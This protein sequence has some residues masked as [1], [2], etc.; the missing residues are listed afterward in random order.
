MKTMRL[1][2]AICI[3]IMA[4][5]CSATKVDESR[6][7][8]SPKQEGEAQEGNEPGNNGQLAGLGS[9]PAPDKSAPVAAGTAQSAPGSRDYQGGN[10]QSYAAAPGSW[11]KAESQPA[12]RYCP[13]PVWPGG[14][15]DTESYDQ[16]EESGFREPRE[17]LPSTFSVDVDTASY[18]NVR[19]FINGGSLPPRD[20]VRI[21]EMVN[22]FDYDYPE[23]ARGKPFS[24]SVEVTRAPW[25]PGHKLVRVAIRARNAVDERRK[26]SNLVFLLDVSGSMSDSNKLPLVKRAMLM[27]LGQLDRRDRVAIVTYA[28]TAGLTL[29]STPADRRGEIRGA[30]ERLEAGGSTAG[31][32]GIQLAY[33]AARENFIRGGI[34]R[35][36]LC[37]DGDFN[38]GISDEVSL[39]RMIGDEAKSGVFLSVFGFGMGNLK[40]SMLEKLAYRGNGFYGYIDNEREARKNMVDQAQGTLVTVAK[41]V[42]IQVEFNPALV[43]SYRLIGYENRLMRA[44]DFANDRKDAGDVG[45]GHRVTAFYEV[46]PAIPGYEEGPAEGF[47]YREKEEDGA[48]FNGEL[49]FVKIRYKEPDGSASRLISFPVR[50]SERG[51]QS[52]STELKFAAAVAEFGLILGESEHRGSANLG[53]VRK[54]AS[55]SIG[56]DNNGYRREF[57]D[58]VRKVEN[59]SAWRTED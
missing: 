35:V 26:P 16:P 37:T 33:S 49:L 15:Y 24:A 57:L 34:N 14:G 55:A 40:D 6:G 58:L 43:Q 39:R 36:I 19:R 51:F 42:K 50:D 1:F 47:R 23:P 31:G 7:R 5:S 46:V 18:A 38:V 2:T 28:G 54:I 10:T 25:A 9:N 53:E 52:A 30:I 29:E 4:V 56:R 12:R 3:A 11:R 32:R 21:E 41:D 22:Y 8:Y 59:M 45:A 13:P 44:E 27:L 48:D 17:H 20:A